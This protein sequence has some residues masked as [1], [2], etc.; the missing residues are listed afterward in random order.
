M[1][2]VTHLTSQMRRQRDLPTF[3][4]RRS[5]DTSSGFRT[6]SPAVPEKAAAAADPCPPPPPPAPR[7]RLFHGIQAVCPSLQVENLLPAEG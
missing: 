3:I 6:D 7:L 2:G 1:E 4:S 5:P